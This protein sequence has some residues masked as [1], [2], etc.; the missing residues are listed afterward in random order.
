M[1]V[2]NILCG[3]FYFN[4]FLQ[5][6]I[7]YHVSELCIGHL[8]NKCWLTGLCRSSISWFCFVCFFGCTHSMQK[9]QGQRWNPHHSSGNAG[10][11]T[12]CTTREFWIVVFV[13]VFNWSVVDLQCFKYIAKWF[14]FSYIYIYTHTH[15]H[16]HTHTN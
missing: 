7:W 8:W 1:T 14:S 3:S 2:V 13:F 6:G 9:F 15:T 10:F 16:T 12:S 5:L 11:L 4:S